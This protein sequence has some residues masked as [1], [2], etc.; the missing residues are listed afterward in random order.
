MM[1]YHNVAPLWLSLYYTNTISVGL[2][3]GRGDIMVEAK[4][5]PTDSV[6]QKVPDVAPEEW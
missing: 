1:F 6:F 2:P 5:L 3:A 4:Y